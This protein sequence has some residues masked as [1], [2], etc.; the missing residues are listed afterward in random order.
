M[1]MGLLCMSVHCCLSRR[2]TIITAENNVECW[3]SPEMK[4]AC[5]HLDNRQSQHSFEGQISFL[6]GFV[7]YER[8]EAGL[9]ACRK[10][11]NKTKNVN[12][13]LGM[14]LIALSSWLFFML[15]FTYCHVSLF[16]CFYF[17]FLQLGLSVLFQ[18][19]LTSLMSKLIR[20]L[21]E[22]AVST[23]RFTLE[24]VQLLVNN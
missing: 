16:C 8:Q 6:F 13:S 23:L 10:K 17:S 5:A 22:K 24:L 20:N 11:Q 15:H 12:T 2:G 14:L 18:I 1:R 9:T 7:F 21:C 19:I 4:G 3:E